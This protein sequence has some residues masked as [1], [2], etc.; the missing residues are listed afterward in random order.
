M[1][2]DWKKNKMRIGET[3]NTN[4]EEQI[5]FKKNERIVSNEVYCCVTSMVEFILTDVQTFAYIGDSKGKIPFAWEDVENL[6]VACGECEGCKTNNGECE[7]MQAQEIYEW[8]AVSPWLFEKL[9]EHGEPV[10]DTYPCLWGRTC[11]GMAI[12]L[13][14]V[15]TKIQRETDV[16]KETGYGGEHEDK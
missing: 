11:T 5:Q 7:E 1:I 3:M 2:G 12:A 13:D 4:E 10:I 9:R 8:W 16:Q 6:Y 14:S 15:I